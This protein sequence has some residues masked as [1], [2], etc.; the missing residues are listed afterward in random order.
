MEYLRVNDWTIAKLRVD[1]TDDEIEYFIDS[2]YWVL[3][4]A[5]RDHSADWFEYKF[6]NLNSGE[7]IYAGNCHAIGVKDY[8][9]MSDF[10]IFC[11]G[12]HLGELF[13][14]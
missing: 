12:A 14:V 10:R 6:Y 11:L 2:T 4:S 1:S 7:Y 3:E 13:R 8:Y 9:P 5:T